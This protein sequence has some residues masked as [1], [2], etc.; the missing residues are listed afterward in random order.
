MSHMLSHTGS[1]TRWSPPLAPFVTSGPGVLLCTS[2]WF[3]HSRPVPPPPSPPPRHFPTDRHMGHFPRQPRLTVRNPWHVLTC[4]SLLTA[5][6]ETGHTEPPPSLLYGRKT[7]GFPPVH[8]MTGHPSHLPTTVSSG[9]TCPIEP[10]LTLA[11]SPVPCPSS[12]SPPRPWKGL[13]MCEWL[14]QPPS[15]SGPILGICCERCPSQRDLQPLPPAPFGSGASAHHALPG[16]WRAPLV[17][18][19]QP[20]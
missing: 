6:E 11:S 5:C 15:S 16:A 9:Q 2:H 18:G 20:F 1:S 4:A 19:L 17:L 10:F 3:S 12:V 7:R 14:L 13:P 8:E